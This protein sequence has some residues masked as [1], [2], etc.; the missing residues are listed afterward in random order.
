MIDQVWIDRST[1][2]KPPQ[3]F[4]AGTPPIAG[5]IGLGAAVDFLKRIGLDRI[6]EHEKRLARMALERLA[7]EFGEIQLYGPRPQTHRAGV[8]SFNLAD[9]HPHDLATILDHEGIAIRA[10]HHCCQPLMQR[11]GSP[12]T[13]RASFYLY[14]EDQDL[15]SLV[16]GLR[17]GGGIFGAS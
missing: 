7:G 2:R 6:H 4:E 12:A 3:K 11:L 8:I 10:G 16:E 1:Y 15:G 17:E 9:I 13:G 14:N 5:A